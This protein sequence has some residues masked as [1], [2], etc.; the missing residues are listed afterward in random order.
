VTS[1]PEPRRLFLTVLAAALLLQAAWIL[2]LP[3][4]SG[5]DEFDHVYKAESVA[6]GQV[7]DDG[8]TE[9]GHGRLLAV[10]EDVVSA[11]TAMCESYDYTGRDN[12]HPGE[13]VAPGLV[14]VASGAATYNPTYYAVVGLLAQPFDGA[15]SDFAMRAYTAIIAALLLSWAAV[16]TSA[17]ARNAWPLVSLL[18][19]VTPVLVY[20]TSVASPNGVGYAA[21]C[22]LW[23]AG[24]G[25][26]EGP[27]RPRVLAL[28]IGALVLM[29]THTTGVLWL[30]V[31]AVVIALLQPLSSWRALY[32]QAQRPLTGAATVV[33]AGG[34]ACVAWVLLAKTN[35]VAMTGVAEVR[36][37]VAELVSAQLVWALQTIGAFPLRNDAAPTVVY[38]LW[39][40]PFLVVIALGLRRASMRVRLAG[41]MLLTAWIA[42]PMTLTLVSYAAEGLAWQGRYALPLAVGFPALAGLALHR[43]TRGPSRRLCAVTVALCALAQVVSCLDVAWG[44]TDKGIVPTF[45]GTGPGAIALIAVLAIAGALAPALLLRPGR[46]PR[47]DAQSMPPAR[48]GVL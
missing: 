45:A 41:A 32:L 44:E 30:A 26:V 35:A 36:V 3:A 31:I 10:P 6:H 14:S 37:P 13:E 47:H 38:V 5:S 43:G 19:A 46:H 48:L 27:R 23:A 18:V 1:A 8:A 25:L 7:L 20:S 29:A 9:A 33:C 39:L 16:V 11:A 40:L 24:L 34:L 17:W 4:F 12:C 21:G 22:L 28:T 2:A 42:V 15:A